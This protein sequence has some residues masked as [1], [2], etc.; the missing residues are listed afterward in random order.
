MKIAFFTA[1]SYDK[2]YF[3]QQLSAFEA[4]EEVENRVWSTP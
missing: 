1:K 4:G 2:Y 3:N